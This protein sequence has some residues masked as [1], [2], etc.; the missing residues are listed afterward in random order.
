MILMDIL[1]KTYLNATVTVGQKKQMRSK[2]NLFY[3]WMEKIKLEEVQKALSRLCEYDLAKFLGVV[4][5]KEQKKI[6]VPIPDILKPYYSRQEISIN[7]AKAYLVSLYIFKTC[8]NAKK[9][10]LIDPDSLLG[11][12]IYA[13]LTVKLKA[14]IP[15]SE[16]ESI[17][18]SDSLAVLLE[19]TARQFLSRPTPYAIYLQREAKPTEILEKEDLL[20]LFINSMSSRWVTYFMFSQGFFGV[21]ILC[22]I[23]FILNAQR[24][25]PLLRW[26]IGGFGLCAF[27]ASAGLFI[28]SVMHA[29]KDLAEIDRIKSGYLKYLPQWLTHQAIQNAD[30]K[31]IPQYLLAEYGEKRS[32]EIGKWEEERK[33]QF[34]LFEMR[35]KIHKDN[36]LLDEERLLELLQQGLEK[37]YTW[38]EMQSFLKQN[39]Q[40]EVLQMIDRIIPGKRSLAQKIHELRRMIRGMA[41][42]IPE[43][44][45]RQLIVEGASVSCDKK[46]FQSLMVKKLEELGLTRKD[47]LSDRFARIFMFLD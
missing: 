11:E 45:I 44:Q 31:I 16:H 25:V 36:P 3:Q 15:S 24:L 29:S 28:T 20:G 18:D 6:L 21:S 39:T 23:Q 7:E 9:C 26:S 14:I 42:R 27:F 13:L 12:S 37:E 8:L 17:S 1:T 33:M 46:Q 35:K 22:C 5:G 2:L 34:F 43:T 32:R 4:F 30:Q 38:P 19:R 10:G 41:I 40:S 47:S